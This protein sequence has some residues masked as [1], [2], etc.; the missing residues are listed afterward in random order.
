MTRAIQI[1]KMAKKRRPP[2]DRNKPEREKQPQAVGPEPDE[3]LNRYISRC[4]ITSRRKADELISAGQVKVNGEVVEELGT[5]LSKSDRV[6]V[7]GKQISPLQNLYILLNKPSDAVTTTSDE[8]GRQTVLD[9]IELPEARSGGLFPV[10]RLDRDTTGVLLLTTDGDLAHRL[11]H[12]SYEIDKL[13][14]VRTR[15]AVKPHQLDQL[16]RGMEVEGET[17][18]ADQATYMRPPHEHE[19][20][21]KLHEG[22]NRQIRRMFESLGHDITHLERVAYAGLTTEGVRRGKWRRLNE[23]EVRRL[24]RLVKLK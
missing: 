6:E 11:M 17:L 14:V 16:T 1:L 8:K 12:P 9:L 2:I 4:G 20:G 18:K 3:R 13:Y 7:N 10:G 23:K 21:L 24:R 19:V 5:K 15:G 22:R